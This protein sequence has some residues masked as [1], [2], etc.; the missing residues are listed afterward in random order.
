MSR[1]RNSVPTYRRHEQSRQAIVTLSDGRAGRQDVHERDQLGK[2]LGQLAA[3][4]RKIA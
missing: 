1:P 2:V 3:H 4:N